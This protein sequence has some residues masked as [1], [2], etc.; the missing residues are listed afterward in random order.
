MSVDGYDIAAPLFDEAAAIDLA[1]VRLGGTVPVLLVGLSAA[2]ADAERL[3]KVAAAQ[4][5]DR[6]EL[7]RVRESEFWKAQRVVYPPCLELFE[8][9]LGWVEAIGHRAAAARDPAP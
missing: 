3:E 7:V 5:R 1:A 4:G 6:V 8:T 9:T 2:A